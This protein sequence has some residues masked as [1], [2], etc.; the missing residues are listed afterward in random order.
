[1]SCCGVVGHWTYECPKKN[2]R[3]EN[4]G[5][6]C[7][8]KIRCRSAV[9]HDQAGRVRGVMESRPGKLTFEA[10]IERTRADYSRVSK[11]IMEMLTSHFD[12]ESR[13]RKEARLRKKADVVKPADAPETGG[14]CI[15]EGQ[16]DK[17][18]GDKDTDS[19]DSEES[20][21][22][23]VARTSESL[24]VSAFISNMLCN[25]MI[26]TGASRSMCSG[27]AARTCSLAST[28]RKINF[29]GI[30][31]ASAEE[32]SAVAVVMLGRTRRITFFVL[33][34]LAVDWILGL[35]DIRAFGFDIDIGNHCLIPHSDTAL[36]RLACTQLDDEL[37]HSNKTRGID[38][39]SGV[40][41]ELTDYE[42]LEHA[43]ALYDSMTIHLQDEDVI[44]RELWDLLVEFKGCW[45]RPRS[46]GV[47]NF[48]ASFTVRGPPILQK[49][50]YLPPEHKAILEDT[51]NDMLKKGVIRPSKSAW[52]SC[53]VFVRKKDGTWR[54][55]LDYRKVNARMEPDG[56]PL[57][58]L[59]P[60]LQMAAGHHY[61]ICLDCNWGF[62]NV[63]VSEPSK[64]YTALITHKG[65]YEFNVVPFGIRNSPGEFQRAI[66][67]V[68]G[69]LYGSG[70]LC[71]VDDI[72]IYA[73]S[74]DK[75]FGLLRAVLG[76]CLESGLY[77]KLAKSEFLKPEVKLLGHLVGL[78]GM[79]PDP[80]KVEAVVKA[81]APKNIAELRSFLGLASYLRRF[82][83]P[84][85][86]AAPYRLTLSKNFAWSAEC[87]E[88]FTTLKELLCEEVI[89]SAPIDGAPFAIM[90][91][92]S[93]VGIGSAL[94]QLVPTGGMIVLELASRKFTAT[95]RRWDT[96]E[97]EAYAISWGEVTTTN[98]NAEAQCTLTMR[99]ERGTT[100][101]G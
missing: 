89:L 95:E 76:R 56:Y 81:R 41:E 51:L 74:T 83:P 37:T 22:M 47:K 73:N 70:V 101:Q 65:T 94:L 24:M 11:G 99:A 39:V 40:R 49:L 21:G 77:L 63:R 18:R 2:S 75:L 26:D 43:R 50:R 35:P 45:L 79:L 72:V 25:V 88:S 12:D 53:P 100:G 55:C 10:P 33:E 17:V 7:H 23:F 71:Y 31:Q 61:Y 86:D 1:M 13:K 44:R 54:I 46:G 87:E 58:L 69:D 42:L 9:Q 90:T 5:K 32:C 30:G 38:H 28:G 4:C 93:E 6:K 92:A 34:N 48:E 97:R 14:V 57:P 98:Y 52:G 78:W 82:V 27:A 91:D 96:R 3:C 84:C 85:C 59:W 67:C 68:L 66:D 15:P 64:Q 36:T 60:N 62:W 19:G 80:K 16:T 29:L 20:F 8:L